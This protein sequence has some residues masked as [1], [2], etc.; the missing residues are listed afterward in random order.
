[1]RTP[2]PVGA[3]RRHDPALDHGDRVLDAVEQGLVI[4]FV[5][6][7]RELDELRGVRPDE[8]VEVK[9]LGSLTVQHLDGHRVGGELGRAVG[10]VLGRTLAGGLRVSSP[11]RLLNIDPAHEGRVVARQVDL[12]P[13]L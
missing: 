9:R 6:G 3:G 11:G 2:P 8:V 13:A 7:G 1:M 10:L 4:G 12:E 5:P